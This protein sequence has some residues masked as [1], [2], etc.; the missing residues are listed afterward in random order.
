MERIKYYDSLRGIAIIAVVF[1]H[2][3]SYQD[4]STLELSVLFRQVINFAVP[5]FL[6]I[7]GFFI[8]DKSVENRKDYF[9]FLKKQIPR[10][11]I[12]YLVW[13]LIFLVVNVFIFNS[14]SLFGMLKKIIVFQSVP[15]FYYV[16]LI[17][18]Y[19][20]LFPVFKLNIKK[21]IWISIILSLSA[22]VT[23]FALKAKFNMTFPLI[24]YAGN[25][26][27]WMM[28]FV[29]GMYLKKHKIQFNKN[30]LTLLII[31][32]LGLSYYEVYFQNNLISNIREAVTAVKITS[33]IYSALIII[34]LLNY[35][36][37]WTIF[38]DLGKVSY[39]VFLMHI[40]F[41]NLIRTTAKIVDVHSNFY[42]E[43]SM[44]IIT[45]TICYGICLVVRKINPSLSYKYLG[46]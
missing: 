36:R 21:W 31:V 23:T 8:V 46:V 16:A 2:C 33:F 27:T 32:F 35:Q 40:L 30:L 37:K 1:I 38:S 44:G 45:I 19:Y 42:T 12:P 14:D 25:F 4:S 39:A 13:S 17:I 28:F 11:Y 41:L 20:I 24:I 29:L 6:A 10:V 15:I 3:L 26:L 18:Q 22:A 9:N 34:F 7:S 5:L 43:I